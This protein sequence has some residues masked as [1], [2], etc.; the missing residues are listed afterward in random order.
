MEYL[1]KAVPTKLKAHYDEAAVECGKANMQSEVGSDDNL[2]SV[3]I[4]CDEAGISRGHQVAESIAENSADELLNGV[5]VEW[6]ERALTEVVDS[7]DLDNLIEP[8]LTDD[9]FDDDVRRLS[10]P[11]LVENRRRPKSRSFARFLQMESMDLRMPYETGFQT[12]R[13]LFVNPRD[14]GWHG[15]LRVS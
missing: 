15:V 3:T 9:N 1:Q 5:E 7:V 14:P 4:D 8:Y 11:W 12:A 13:S 2:S 10:G 6:D